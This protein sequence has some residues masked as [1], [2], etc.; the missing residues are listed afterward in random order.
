LI[1]ILLSGGREETSQVSSW[2]SLWP[3]ESKFGNV[4]LLPP[5]CDIAI[6]RDNTTASD[7]IDS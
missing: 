5:K 6:I 4:E 2:P 1:V 7:E 3:G